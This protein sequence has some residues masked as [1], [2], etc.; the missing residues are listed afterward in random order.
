MNA[1]AVVT[2][3]GCGVNADAA[4]LVPTLDAQ[5]RAMM[6]ANLWSFKSN[7]EG[8]GCAEGAWTVYVPA[9]GPDTGP[10]PPNGALQ[11]ERQQ[12]MGR[13]HPRGVV[14]GLLFY[15]FNTTTQAFTMGVN[16]TAAT[17]ERVRAVRASPEYAASSPWARMPVGAPLAVSAAAYEPTLPA[18]L[19]SN[20]TVT[21]VFLPLNVPGNVSVTGAA[22]LQSVMTWPDG[23]RS[24]YVAPTGVGVYYVFVSGNGNATSSAAAAAQ[25][26]E[27]EEGDTAGAAEAPATDAAQLDA[28]RLAHAEAAIGAGLLDADGAPLPPADVGAALEVGAQAATALSPAEALALW[29]AY[30]RGGVEAAAKA[31]RLTRRGR[32]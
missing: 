22:V 31:L 11:P 3:F 7:C 21:E 19:A 28:A 23:S 4:L 16:V 26:E 2:E 15:G 32:Q 24:A 27:G 8:A 25:E 14:G 9:P 30:A 18:A 10:I 5:D 1:A 13:V 6:G 29:R 12:L 17:L 20:G